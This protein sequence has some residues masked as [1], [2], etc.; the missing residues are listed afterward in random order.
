MQTHT[1]ASQQYAILCIVIWHSQ[2]SQQSKIVHSR[3]THPPNVE[4]LNMSFQDTMSFQCK[5]YPKSV[6][7]RLTHPPKVETINKSVTSRHQILPKWTLSKI[8][9]FHTTT[10]S[11]QGNCWKAVISRSPNPLK[12][13]TVKNHS[14]LYSHILPKWKVSKISPFNTSHPHKVKTME[15]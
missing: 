6:I 8:C 11:Q 14:F 13:V 10:S 4:I 12:V 1:H 3:L 2:I 15:N 5:N 9:P 7:S